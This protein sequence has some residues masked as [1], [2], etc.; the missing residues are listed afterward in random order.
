MRLRVTRELDGSVDGIQLSQFRPGYLYDVGTSLACYL[1]AIG[2]AEPLADERPAL[3]VPLENQLL[4][5]LHQYAKDPSVRHDA[6]PPLRR[7]A[8]KRR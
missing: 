3:V 8:K 1:L 4:Q 7:A 5:E 2:A 6:A